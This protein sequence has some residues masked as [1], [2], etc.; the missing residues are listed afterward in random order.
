MHW[1]RYSDRVENP[2]ADVERIRTIT[3]PAERA[4]EIG[5]VLNALP[6]VMAELRAMRQAAVLEMRAK[7][8]S[9]AAIA[10]EL[11]VHRNRAQNIAEGRTG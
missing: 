10:A 5:K 4:R 11:G 7:G 9:H 3:D 2:L 6:E 8:M 1:S